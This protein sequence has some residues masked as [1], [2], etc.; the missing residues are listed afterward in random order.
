[1]E[2]FCSFG[3]RDGGIALVAKNKAG[4]DDLL[5]L[6]T[7]LFLVRRLYELWVGLLECVNYSRHQGE[8]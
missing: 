3:R 4:H 7:V 5:W 1:M 6:V 8:E 2:R